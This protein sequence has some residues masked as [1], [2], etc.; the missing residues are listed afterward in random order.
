MNDKWE[1]TSL[2]GG[3][4]RV[5]LRKLPDHFEKILPAEKVEKTRKL[6]IVSNIL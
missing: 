4:K 2:L 5:L 3:E 1:W 6:W